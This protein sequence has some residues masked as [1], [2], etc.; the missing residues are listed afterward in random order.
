MPLLLISGKSEAASSNPCR[1]DRQSTRLNSRHTEIYTLSLHDALP[2]SPAQQV[3]PAAIVA[4]KANAPAPYFR[5]IR[6]CQLQSVSCRSAEHTSELQAHR[7]LHSFPT[8]RSSDLTGAA[9]NPGCHSR[10]ESECPCSLFPANQRL[11]APIRV[12]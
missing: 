6:G 3:I 10:A 5:Q 1:V 4:Q 7:D 8:R 2:I 11:P 12:V 9:S